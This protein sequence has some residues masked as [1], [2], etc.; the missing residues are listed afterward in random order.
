MVFL[1]PLAIWL[2][3]FTFIGLV[4]TIILGLL[5]MKGKAPFK[6]HKITAIATICLAVVHVVFAILLWFFGVVI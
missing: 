2:G 4:K 3:F 5:V 1:I 6:Y